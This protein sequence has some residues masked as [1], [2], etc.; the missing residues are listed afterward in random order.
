MNKYFSGKPFPECFSYSICIFLPDFLL[1]LFPGAY[2]KGDVYSIKSA[3]GI[4]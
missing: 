2:K 3:Y 1:I 4:M